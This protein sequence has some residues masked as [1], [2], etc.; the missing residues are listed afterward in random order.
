MAEHGVWGDAHALAPFAY[1]IGMPFISRV[2]S[3]SLQIPIETAFRIVTHGFALCLLIGIFV[4]AREFVGDCR[5]AIMTMFLLGLS[6]VHIKFPLFFF[7][8][9]DVSAYAL[10]VTAFWALIT[11][12]FTLCLIVSS[13]GLLFKEWLAV[14]WFVLCTHC[15]HQWYREMSVRNLAYLGAAAG[16][17]LSAILLPR[18]LIPV[19]GTVQFVDPLNAPP[20][21]S[22]LLTAPLDERRWFNIAYSLAGYWLPTMLL[23]TGSRAR[24]VWDALGAFVL[25]SMG[26]YVG[27]VLILTMY[28]GTN[29]SIFVGYCVPVQTV[30]L[31]LLFR[32]GI[33]MWEIVYVTL[34]MLLYNKTLLHIPLPDRDFDAYIDFYGGWSDR[35]SLS[36]IMRFLEIGVFMVLAHCIR[37]LVDIAKTSDQRAE[38]N[39]SRLH[40]VTQAVCEQSQ[41]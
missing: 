26:I 6:A 21:L 39:G 37:T 8:L 5:H 18:L 10:I 17:G 35:V 25:Y 19:A 24:Q 31:A 30:I 23:L 15:A 32:N 33:K 40:P 38:S 3:D 7:T 4:L 1:R 41:G 29:I 34:A 27:L 16:L 12:Q 2:V 13:V 11:H 14:P 9:V 28:G 22:V 20:S 36:T